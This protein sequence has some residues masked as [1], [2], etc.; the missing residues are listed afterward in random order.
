MAQPSI[1]IKCLLE[2]T[3]EAFYYHRNKVDQLKHRDYPFSC[4]SKLLSKLL[5]I[6]EAILIELNKV[7]LE[8]SK[9]R[10][11]DQE[12]AFVEE[13][14]DRLQRYGQL[15]G[16]LNSMLVYFE[17]GSREF[18]HEGTAVP[19]GTIL[20]KF[21]TESSFIL[22]PLFDYNYMYLDVFRPLKKSLKN[23]LP[24]DYIDNL[25]SDMPGKYAVFGLPLSLKNNIILNAILSH[26]LGHFLDETQ[27]LSK[28]V[29]KKVNL[30]EAKLEELAKKMEKSRMGDKDVKSPGTLR[31]QLLKIA[32]R[33]IFDWINELVSDDI[34]FHLFGPV[35]LYSM[36]NFLLTL[37]KLDEASSDHPSPR[38]RIQLLLEEF[39]NM[40]YSATLCS[41]QEVSDKKDAE[42]FVKLSEELRK[43]LQNMKKDQTSESDEALMFQEIVTDAVKSV[44]TE[45]RTEVHQLVNEH[46]YKPIDFKNDVFALS[47]ILGFV[48]PPSEKEVGKPASCISILNAGTLYK[49]LHASELNSAF[50][51]KTDIETLEVRDRINGLILKAL[52]LQDLQLRMNRAFESEKK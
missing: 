14:V 28:K 43:L 36:S 19:I 12:K 2:T 23:A 48:V 26:E 9:I 37:V 4:C 25:F 49:L 52:E 35:F 47:K 16:V 31:A 46:E 21:D 3:K 24:Q 22:V 39:D 41:I 33:Q 27:E 34:A 50:D 42:D 8:I 32:A 40:N 38:L 7:D 11:N 30:N 17:L 51:A 5:V 18:V 6:D 45:I 15:L 44:V 10:N 1:L 13:S 20:R 29:L